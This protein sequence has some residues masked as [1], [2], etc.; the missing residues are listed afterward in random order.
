MGLQ[1][2]EF[3]LAGPNFNA[4]V[5]KNV[6][7]GYDWYS[8]WSVDLTID[9][10]SNGSGI[11][12]SDTQTVDLYGS[13]LFK[14]LGTLTLAP[15]MIVTLKHTDSEPD[16]TIEKSL[17]VSTLMVTQ[18]NPAADT[19]SGMGPEGALI[20]V[21]YCANKDCSWRRWVT[22][23]SGHWLADF[24]VPGSMPDEQSVLDIKPG[25]QGDAS[26]QDE[27]GDSTLSLWSVPNPSIYTLLP[28]YGGGNKAEGYD[29]PLAASVTLNIDDPDNGIGLDYTDTQTV[30]TASW[31][32]NRTWVGFLPG[33]FELQPGQLLTMSDG[34]TTKEYTIQNLVVT[35]VDLNA[36]TTSGTVEPNTEVVMNL[37]CGPSTCAALRRETSDAGGHWFMDFSEPGNDPDEQDVAD[38]QAGM[39]GKLTAYDGDGDATVQPWFS[40]HEISGHVGVQ[41]GAVSYTGGSIPVAPTS[42]GFYSITVATGWSGTVTPS[43][44]GYAFTPASRTYSAVT[45]DLANQDFTPHA[46]ASVSYRSIGTQDGWILE[47]GENTNLGGSLSAATTTFM[48]GDNA[49]RRQYRAILSFNTSTLPDNAVIKSARITL[50]RQFIS[51]GGNPLSIFQ[52][53][54]IDVRKG[55]FGTST[56]L[57][58]ADFQATAHKAGIGPYNPTPVGTLYTINLNSTAFPYINKLNTGGGVTQLRLRFKLDDNNNT[59]ANFISF[60]SG[61][62]GTASYRPTLIVTYYRP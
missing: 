47:T 25:M 45:T 50:R 53:L 38:I 34:I 16:L 33:S 58:A 49:S 56:G 30:T 35:N 4:T 3:G 60:Y 29:W 59:V 61:N 27:D 26:Q 13:V 62:Y 12:F 52:G 23:E 40:T 14:S 24:S 42:D 22:V 11:D 18:T 6:V 20:Q 37:N 5:G 54:L 17:T 39:N 31:D 57:L 10:P 48:L 44:S 36:D 9:D 21:E 41:G 43:A 15:E 8:G 51:G 46:M 7:Q 1:N 28:A 55:F 2:Q 19:V 32:P